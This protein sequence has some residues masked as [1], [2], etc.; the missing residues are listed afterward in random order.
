MV[1]PKCDQE[2]GDAV[3]GFGGSLAVLEIEGA[4]G[5]RRGNRRGMEV[6]GAS[7]ELVSTWRHA[8]RANNRAIKSLG[9]MQ[10]STKT[11][12]PLSTR[13]DVRGSLRDLESPLAASS[14][15]IGFG[16]LR[17]T[18]VDESPL[19]CGISNP[20]RFRRVFSGA[21]ETGEM[22][23]SQLVAFKTFPSTMN[24]TIFRP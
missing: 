11:W 5:L 13:E 3:L 17:L 10:S 7:S 22:H 12:A 2:A 19:Q 20:V 6:V 14:F 24:R 23:F 21:L 18:Q 16:L 4:P 8:V 9:G 15:R 1:S